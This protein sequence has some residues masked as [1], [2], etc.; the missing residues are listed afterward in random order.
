MLELV[1]AMREAVGVWYNVSGKETC[2]AIGHDDD[3]DDEEAEGGDGPESAPQLSQ[4]SKGAAGRAH[5]T[6]LLRAA[7]SHGN[8]RRWHTDRSFVR[9]APEGSMPLPSQSLQCPACPPCDP[10]CPHCP[11][12]SCEPGRCNYTGTLSKTFSWETV[13]CNED[14]FLYNLDVTV[15]RLLK[16]SYLS[17][18]T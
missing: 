9:A 16:Y 5:R 15:S 2:F 4:P 7:A 6:A 17:T 3:D 1:A 18:P 8:P 10:P 11:I 12:A 14:L 13:T